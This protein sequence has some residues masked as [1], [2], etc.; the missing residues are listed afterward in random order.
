MQ[1][2]FLPQQPEVANEKEFKLC[3]GGGTWRAARTGRAISEEVAVGGEGA[4]RE[5]AAK[6]ADEMQGIS[7][8]SRWE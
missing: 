4:E 8:V 6:D 3:T 7:S 2:L 1:G 5:P